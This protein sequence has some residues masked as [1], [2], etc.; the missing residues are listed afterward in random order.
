MASATGV[1]Q[2]L[3]EVTTRMDKM[4]S[5]IDQL[6]TNAK[7][8]TKILETH[9]ALFNTMLEKLNLLT[10]H[11]YIPI[12]PHATPAWPLPG[13]NTPPPPQPQCM[14]LDIDLKRKAPTS[15]I[16]PPSTQPPE[17]DNPSGDHLAN[18]PRPPFHP[19]ISDQ[20]GTGNTPPPNTSGG[21]TA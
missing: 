17:S 21:G 18:E 6:N 3:G 9:S 13:C 20:R 4:E 16:S 12:P 15:P 8:T 14:A 11:Q 10:D 5:T 1:A 7:E 2:A 19:S